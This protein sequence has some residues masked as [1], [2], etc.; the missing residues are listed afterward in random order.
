MKK[1]LLILI[2]LVLL[3]MLV[4]CGETDSINSCEHVW[5]SADCEHAKTCALCAETQ[6]NALGHIEV[7]DDGVPVTCTTDGITRGRHC[8]VCNKVL[9]KQEK[10]TA[11][12]HIE[13]IDKAVPATCT[14][15]GLTQGKHCSVCNEILVEQTIIKAKGHNVVVIPE[16]P[17]TC[18]TA[19]LTEGK[20]CSECDYVLTEQEIIPKTEHNIAH[21]SCANCGQIT[22]A[23]DALAYYVLCNGKID[24]DGEYYL[25]NG[26]ISDDGSSYVYIVYTDAEAQTLKFCSL[27]ETSNTEVFTMMTLARNGNLQE[28]VMGYESLGYTDYTFGKIYKNTFSSENK[29][30]YDFKYQGNFPSL[31]SKFQA[32][33]GTSVNL[34]LTGVKAFILADIDL[35]ITMSMLGFVNY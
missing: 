3:G 6:G 7:I 2:S 19:G 22:N 1:I 33:F 21:G 15:D 27:N 10:I 9:Q 16:E 32:L 20:Q 23:Y 17:A 4:A 5:V 28:V 26:Y 14:E 30:I 8:S 25:I 24:D 12:G 35:D 13:V 11:N 34:L 31:S 29:Y 18:L